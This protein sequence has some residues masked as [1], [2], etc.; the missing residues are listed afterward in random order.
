MLLSIFILFGTVYFNG[1]EFSRLFFF[2]PETKKMKSYEKIPTT[3]DDQKPLKVKVYKKRWL[4]LLIFA[5]N[6]LANAVLFV[7]ITSINNIACRYYNISPALTD[8]AGNG[9]NIVYVFIALPSAYFMDSFGVRTLVILGSSLNAIG[10]CLHLAGTPREHGIVYVLS[11]QLMAGLSMGAILQVPARLATVWFPEHEQAKALS[12]AFVFNVSGLAIGFL[13]P[14]YMVPDSENMDEIYD[15][16]LRMN[17]SHVVLLA[18]CLISA[19]LFFDEKPPLPPSY[20]KAVL[21]SSSVDEH[22]ETPGFKLSLKLLFTDRNFMLLAL[23]YGLQSGLYSMFVTCLNEMANTIVSSSQIGW[24]GFLGNL[25]SIVGLMLLASIADKYKCYKKITTRLFFVQILCWIAFSSTILYWKTAT[26]LF[27][28][29][30]FLCFFNT[31]FNAVGLSFAT[32]VS[33]PVTEGMSTAIVLMITNT[34]GFINIL[35]FGRLVDD[36][37]VFLMC[38]IVTGMY[39]VAF[40][41]TFFVNEDLKRSKLEGQHNV[42][43]LPQVSKEA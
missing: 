11:G 42:K 19:Y 37:Y 16:L 18:V 20:A 10:V 14:S 8:W 13:Q 27:V 7:S 29:Y 33:Y 34:L 24:I 32:E 1:C 43:P 9:F 41:L 21:D 17:I 40:I 4:I 26:S 2:F 6:S 28:T 35:I 22:G 25:V 15:G 12:L 38:S 3:E 23:V 36:G 31:S 39:V 5:I 30:S